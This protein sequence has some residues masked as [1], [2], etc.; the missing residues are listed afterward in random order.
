VQPLF[1]ASGAWLF[2]LFTPKIEE[3]V[4][5]RWLRRQLLEEGPDFLVI[6]E[7]AAWPS[8][9]GQDDERCVSAKVWVSLT[10]MAAEMR[11]HAVSG[12]IQRCFLCRRM[13]ILFSPPAVMEL[14][15]VVADW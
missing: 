4:P 3:R 2:T 14:A 5:D 10:Q 1:L 7:N 9:P 12:I 6:L 15:I 13:S 8:L 11:Q